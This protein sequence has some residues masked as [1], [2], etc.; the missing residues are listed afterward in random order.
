MKKLWIMAMAAG[1]LCG[2]PQQQ[3]Q[4]Q[5]QNPPPVKKVE[6]PAQD[7][8]PMV[9]TQPADRQPPVKESLAPIPPATPQPDSQAKR[10]YTVEKGD[11]LFS[12]SRKL[13]GS[14]QRVKDIK[15]LNPGMDPDKLKVGQTINVPQ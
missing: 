4:P 5:A 14:N 8:T 2:C 10:T 9:A 3:A 1:F 12:I 11:T 6:P 13:Y 7:M 15:A